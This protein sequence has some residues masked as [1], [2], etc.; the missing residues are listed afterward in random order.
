[1]TAEAL[2]EDASRRE[3]KSG[4]TGYVRHA[5][6]AVNGAGRETLWSPAPPSSVSCHTRYREICSTTSV[7]HLRPFPYDYPK[8][9]FI[10]EPVSDLEQNPFV[11]K[12]LFGHQPC[13]VKR[14]QRFGNHLH[15][16]INCKICNAMQRAMR[17][18]WKGVLFGVHLNSKGVPYVT[19]RVVTSAGLLG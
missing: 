9:M 7:C 16:C 6:E 5:V 17:Q 2:G 12:I 11:N 8:I 19:T 18:D 4:L 1:M 3:S 14:N 15:R 13:Q 10:L